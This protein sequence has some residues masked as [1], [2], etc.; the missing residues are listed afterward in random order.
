MSYLTLNGHQLSTKAASVCKFL[1]DKE[2]MY[3]HVLCRGHSGV[4]MASVIAA[5]AKKSL[6]ILRKD[7]ESSHGSLIEHNCDESIQQS[8]VFVDDLI[9]TGATL[10][11]VVKALGNSILQVKLEAVIFYNQSMQDA[12]EHKKVLVNMIMGDIPVYWL[13]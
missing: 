9:D 12:A 1:R 2:I 6:I 3:T 8:C 7:G 5:R 11:A 10:K 4:T 13:G